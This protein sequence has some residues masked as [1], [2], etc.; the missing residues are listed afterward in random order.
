MSD[1]GLRHEAGEICA[2]LGY[3]TAYGDNFLPT[4]RDN[5]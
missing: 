5:L 4:F 2:L 3:C 1:L